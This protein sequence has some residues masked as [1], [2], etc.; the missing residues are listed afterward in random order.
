MKFLDS[1]AG[2][3]LALTCTE[4]WG[5]NHGADDRLH[6]PGVEATVR[7]RP[8]AAHPEGGDVFFLSACSGARMSRITL[9][10]VAGHGAPVAATA[11]RLRALVGAFVDSADQ[12]S[13]ARALNASFNR[14]EAPG[15]FATA[16]LASFD[17][18]TGALSVVNAGH[19]R[20][21]VRRSASG[22]WDVLDGGDRGAGAHNLPLG[23]V[24]DT[25][26]RAFTTELTPGDTVIMYT[27]GV[28][29]AVRRERGRALTERELSERAAA[30]CDERGL[31]DALLDRDTPLDDDATVITLTVRPC[32]T[33]TVT[34][35][36][37]VSAFRSALGRRAA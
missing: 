34:V 21:L 9:A 8:H 6:L 12:A 30:A 18:A 28:T 36:D 24:S 4:L 22:S 33:P 25:E 27:D 11:G 31:V 19:P 2:E 23:I 13:Y 17:A 14:D 3:G 32:L 37:R 10:D 1:G 15:T 5:G 29:D 7:A 35:R 20:P 26:Y 16:L